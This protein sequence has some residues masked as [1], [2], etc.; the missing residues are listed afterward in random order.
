MED[1]SRSDCGCLLER[2]A[3]RRGTLSR[4]ESWLPG[5]SQALSPYGPISQ[6]AVL[7]FQSLLNSACLSALCK[8]AFVPYRNPTVH[9]PP[10][11][12]PG[13]LNVRVLP[14][15]GTRDQIGVAM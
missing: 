10:R 1:G 12:M 14:G 2:E 5:Q 9:F 11:L 6:V 8:V 15:C 3:L 4:S 7:I 13:W